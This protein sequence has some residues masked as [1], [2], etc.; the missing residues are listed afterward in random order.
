MPAGRERLA[1]S[2]AALG[3]PW[4][5]TSAPWSKGT[6]DEPAAQQQFQWEPSQAGML[7]KVLTMAPFLLEIQEPKAYFHPHPTSWSYL[8][9]CHQL[10]GITVTQGMRAG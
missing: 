4:P 1:Q 6:G 2:R 7:W 10:S 8:E 9:S 5:M 3:L